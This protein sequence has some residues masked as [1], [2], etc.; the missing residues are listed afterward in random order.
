MSAGLAG[1]NEV[2][3]SWVGSTGVSQYVVERSP[4]GSTWSVVA[5]AV[6]A[7]SFF[8]SGLNFSTT[9]YYR[10]MAISNAGNSP[11]SSIVS[12]QTEAQPDVLSA[13]S[14]VLTATRGSL[15]SGAVA[16]F[17]DA[18]A[19][20]GTARFIATI[21]WGDG[22]FGQGAVSGGD[23]TFLISGAHTYAKVG[24]F[25]VQVTVTMSWPDQAS[26]SATGTA[27]VGTPAKHRP[28]ARPRAVHHPLKKALRL[29]KRRIR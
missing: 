23:G 1:R 5:A 21:N 2:S 7:T 26:A 25:A 10:V 28:L 19:I 14:L 4:D 6:T 24:V 17:T 11:A 18:N 12:A 15:F 8:D 27:Q 22:T 9:Y 16:T 3:L 29:A 20:T 13:Q